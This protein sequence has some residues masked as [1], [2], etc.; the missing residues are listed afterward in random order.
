MKT[1]PKTSTLKVALCD[2]NDL[3]GH[4]SFHEKNMSSECKHSYKVLIKL[5]FKQNK[6][7]RKSEF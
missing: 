2:L 3:L 5:D 7:L 4:T 1:D 6:Y